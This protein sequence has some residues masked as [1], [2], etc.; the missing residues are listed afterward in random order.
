[1]FVTCAD[2]A[3][4]SWTPA[5]VCRRW[6]QDVTVARVLAVTLASLGGRQSSNSTRREASTWA[7]VS[8]DGSR[9]D[10]CSRP[11]LRMPL[12]GS[13]SEWR[14]VSSTRLLTRSR[15][16]PARSRE[17]PPPWGFTWVGRS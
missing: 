12:C 8:V 1:M 14:S 10:T 6:R 9:T 13:E 17:R 7:R 3:V 11:N 16:G 4:H 5:T 15:A 2:M